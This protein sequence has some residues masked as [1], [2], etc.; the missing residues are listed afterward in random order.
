MI[1]RY[2][3]HY[4]SAALEL[5]RAMHEESRFR[6]YPFAD[7]R[8]LH[9]LERPNVFGAFSMQRENITGFFLGVVQ[10]MWFSDIRF[11]FDLALYIKPEFRRRTL[12]P[13]RLIGEFE[14]F[15][16]EQG[17][18]EVNLGSTA[19]ISTDSARR[20]YARLGY[21]ECGFVAR[22]EL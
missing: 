9:L 1:V 17:C 2:S 3:P 11:G 10:A 6:S 14:K 18:S 21:K 16:R 15:C 13:V 8:I 12:D 22:K 5:G 4:R 7:E 20:L 19:E